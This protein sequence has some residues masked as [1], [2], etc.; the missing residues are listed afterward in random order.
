M[1]GK[2][3]LQKMIEL[4]KIRTGVIEMDPLEIAK[5]AV[6]NGVELP[7]PVD[8]FKQL[9]K[10][11]SEAAR[12]V[13]RTD[14]ITGRP[15]RAYHSLPIKQGQETFFFW[16]D[17]DDAT[18]PQMLRSS[19]RRREQVVGE[20]VQHTFDLEHWAAA[21]PDKEPIHLEKDFNLDVAI[22]MASNDDE[23]A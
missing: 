12:E 1:A 22:R 19:N 11:I 6:A 4:Y 15:Y 23:A 21:N 2:K 18:R 8:P 3:T 5:F 17:I 7:A 20:L 14:R 16:V 10:Q 13:V 9:V